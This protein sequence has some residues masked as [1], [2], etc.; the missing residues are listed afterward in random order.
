M[1]PTSFAVTQRASGGVAMFVDIAANVT[2]AQ[3]S[4]IAALIAGDSVTAQG[5]YAVP[6]NASLVTEAIAAAHATLPRVDRVIV[7]VLDHTHDASG[8]NLVQS[9]VLTGTASSGANLT[10]LTGAASIPDSSLLLADVLVGATV[11]TITN[12]VI[13]DRRKW[14]RGTYCRTIRTANA[15]STNDYARTASSVLAL[16]DGT[17]LAPRVECSGVPMR[18]TLTGSFV[19]ST[20]GSVLLAGQI[21]GVGMD[22]MGDVGEDVSAGISSFR[23]IF[24]GASDERMI[25]L[26]WDFVPSAGSHVIGPAWASGGSVNLTARARADRPLMWT[27]EEIVRSNTPNNAVTS[28]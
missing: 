22:N 24:A 13:R 5:L 18:A 23:E 20:A 3:G 2:D 6:P 28:G 8:S 26:T 16:I 11:T 25:T 10:N 4:G 21:D 1:A 9:R 7:Q 19:S 12:G 27:V 17:N 15:S 14:T